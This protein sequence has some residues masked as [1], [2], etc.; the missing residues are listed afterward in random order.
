MEA[1]ADP[2]LME[3]ARMLLARAGFL[4]LLDGVDH[5]ALSMTYPDGLRPDFI[6]LIWSPRLTDSPAAT[7]AVIDA[8]IE[9]LG[10]E[11]IVLQRAEGEEA[12]AWGQ[13]RGITRYQGYF[14]DA[15]L[16]ASRIAGCHSARA[17]SLRQCTTR[18]GTLNPAVR[19][20]CGNPA[21]LDMP[22]LLP[23]AH[24]TH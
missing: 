3:Y 17:C 19:G 8:A 21:W 23:P 9:R 12:L 4:L 5:I 24:G 20:G 13:A 2:A 11:R 18:A 10:P 16:G 6:K 1:G 15:V 22:P 7:L 14:L